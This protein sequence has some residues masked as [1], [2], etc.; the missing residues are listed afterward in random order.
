M[1]TI[2]TSRSFKMSSFYYMQA[3]IS[4]VVLLEYI[5]ELYGSFITCCTDINLTKQYKVSISFDNS[6]I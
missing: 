6:E 4:A 3:Y 2:Y 1:F 5:L